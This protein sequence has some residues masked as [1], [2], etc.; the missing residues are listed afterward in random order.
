MKKMS[1]NASGPPTTEEKRQALEL[2]LGSRTLARADQL[3]SLL[4]YLCK[5][6]AEGRQKDLSEYV[7][8]REVL[9]RPEDYSPTED[10]SVRTRAYEL[11]HRL[12]KL[13]LLEAPHAPLRIVL[14]KGT[15]VPQYD[16][17]PPSEEAASPALA[18]ESGGPIGDV[19]SG[20]GPRPSWVWWVLAMSVMISL[21][22]I[23]AVLANRGAGQQA[24]DP[25]I[26]EAW[27]PLAQ[28]G[29][30][31]L[32]CVATPLHLTVGPDTHAAF[33][34]LI[35]PAPEEA[36]PLWCQHRPLAPGA[37]LGMVFSDNM[38][39]FG[40]MNSILVA[41]NTLRRM[42]VTHQIF[43]ERVAPI[44][45]FRNR[46]VMLFGAP[47]DS[48]A[49]TRLH[50]STPLLVD[51]E[52]SVREFV[53]RDRKTGKMT[54]PQKDERGE[55]QAVYGLITVLHNRESDR[56]KLGTVM[57]SGITSAG[58]HGAAEYF[59]SP[60]SLQ[61]LRALLA[62]EGVTRFPAAYQVVVRCTFGNALL[63]SYECVEYRILD[64]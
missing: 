14:P 37:K 5:V 16:W 59:A 56:G 3:R 33:G 35:Y 26:K 28:P 47:V 57:F 55:F 27:G 18:A 6:E 34:S 15:Y 61:D 22:G 64:K 42:G 8:G 30:S 36:Y 51:Y 49:V 4:Q 24:V 2:A 40:T 9:G 21:A 20:T 39:G 13:Y 54:V 1:L 10:S 38:I 31:V 32:M 11:R 19:T 12:E 45:T 48:D 44:S 58:T 17:A 23:Y 29:A 25:I 46:N 52:P 53:I 62:R 43:P 7:I 50:E 41:V 63:L 60:R